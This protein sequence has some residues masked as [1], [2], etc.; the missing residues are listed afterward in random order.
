[1]QF[2]A[3]PSRETGELFSE[4]ANHIEQ[5]VKKDCSEVET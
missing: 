4:M 1:M 5:C 3:I 2:F